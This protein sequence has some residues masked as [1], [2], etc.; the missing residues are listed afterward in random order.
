MWDGKQMTGYTVTT[1]D[2]VI[3]AK[4]LP[5]DVSSQKAKLIALTTVLELSEGSTSQ[6]LQKFIELSRPIG[7][8]PPVHQFQPGDRVY[9]KWWD[10]EPS[11]EDYSKF[12]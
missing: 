3:K 7:L 1:K 9:I 8:D 12:C 11:G 6:K 2:E 5:A 4:A 10:S